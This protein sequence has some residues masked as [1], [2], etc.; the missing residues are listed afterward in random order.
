VYR[1]TGS[2]VDALLVGMVGPMLLVCLSTLN[3]PGIYRVLVLLDK[4]YKPQADI[5]D[6]S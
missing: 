4:A 2:M 3:T 1:V 6:I 5:P